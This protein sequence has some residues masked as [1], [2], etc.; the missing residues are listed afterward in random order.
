MFKKK[1]SEP[2]RR[3]LRAEIESLNRKIQILEAEII[4]LKKP[5]PNFKKPKSL[6][7]TDI[8]TMKLMREEGFSNNK[9]ARKFNVTEGTIRNYFKNEGG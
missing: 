2:S 9:I 3:E 4:E 7:E 6:N 5:N 1:V 8:E